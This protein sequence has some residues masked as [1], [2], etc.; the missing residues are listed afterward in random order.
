MNYLTKSYIIDEISKKIPQMKHG[1]NPLNLISDSNINLIADDF[2]REW[3]NVGD[4]E[5]DLDYTLELFIMY[6]YEF[7]NW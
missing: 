6:F 4:Y 2:L 5:A 3:D 7:K 1:G